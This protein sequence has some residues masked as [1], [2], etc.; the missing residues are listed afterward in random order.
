MYRPWFFHT[1]NESVWTGWPEAGDGTN[2]PPMVMK[3]GFGVA[4][5]FNVRPVR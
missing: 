3:N 2:I 4:G 5:L 1:V